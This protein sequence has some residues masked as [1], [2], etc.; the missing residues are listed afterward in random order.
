MSVVTHN[1]LNSSLHDR[2]EIILLDTADRRGLANMGRLDLVN[3][4]LAV[5]LGVRFLWLLV[6]RRPDIV[7]VCIAQNTLGYLRDCLFL[8]PAHL[9]RHRVVAHLH[10]SVFR[11]FYRRSLFPMR[12]LIRWTLQGVR[13]MIVLGDS[14]RAL[15]T[16]LVPGERLTVIPN[17]IET[18]LA[19]VNTESGQHAK[20]QH[21][22][23]YLG[24]LKESKGFMEVLRS[25]SLVVGQEPSA[26]FVLAGEDC[27]PEEMQKAWEFIRKNGLSDFVNMLGVVAGSE[28]A[29]LLS[30]AEAFI[31]PPIAPEGQPLVILE[32]MSAG[33]PVI[34][35]PQGAIAETVV[36]GVTGFLVPVG[37]PVAIAEKILLLIRN[38]DLR[39]RMGQAGRE[40]F[41]KYYTVERWAGDLARVFREV[42]K[43]N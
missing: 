8:I 20:V 27:Y 42:L 36:D 33:L 41:L 16:G 43:E 30:E 32:A 17:G 13:R 38:A 14:M 15:F 39:R 3:V 18:I 29:R 24:T 26:R 25:V 5:Q 19:Y 34:A 40:R 10:G 11:S 28:K 23:V 7:Y 37:D 35:T 9:L 21:N 6:T 31:F 22:V 2:F 12:C 4:A 1:L